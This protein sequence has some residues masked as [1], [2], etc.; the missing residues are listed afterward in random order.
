MKKKIIGTAVAVILALAMVFV[1]LNFSEQ[2]AEG[3]KNVT[4]E[5]TSQS[6]EVTTYDVETEALYL[7]EVMEEIEALTF[8]ID[9][10]MI[11]TVNGETADYNVNGAYWALYVN[12]EYGNYGADRQ[13]VADGDVFGITYTVA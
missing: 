5:I 6:G 4:V 7:I 1:Y 2:T 3:S 13:P 9:E 10:G 11:M 12:G 8:T